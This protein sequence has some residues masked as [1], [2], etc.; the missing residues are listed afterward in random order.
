MLPG[1]RPAPPPGARLL[2]RAAFDALWRYDRHLP[3]DRLS[4]NHLSDYVRAYLLA[5]HG[6][7]YLDADCVP[8]QP[9]DPAL[10]AAQTHGFVTYREPPGHLS[11]NFM[12]A[13][14]GNAIARDHYARVVRRIEAGPPLAWLDLASTPLGAAIDATEMPFAELP[15][16]AIMPLPYDRSAALAIER[17]DTAHAAYLSSDCLCYMLANATIRALPETK[18]LA[19][20]SADEILAH[21]SFL[22]FLLRTAFRLLPPG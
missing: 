2:D 12:A 18:A 22:G 11:C 1:H 19:A 7:L 6:G 13:T 9:L 4:L 5:H 14:P 20:L 21:P 16:A 10:A 3:I 17:D 15:R 8:L